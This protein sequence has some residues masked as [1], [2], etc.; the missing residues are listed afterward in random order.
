M[1][2]N[3]VASATFNER[4]Y[5]ALKMLFSSLATKS[6][7]SSSDPGH[8]VRCQRLVLWNSF[9]NNNTNSQSYGSSV[10]DRLPSTCSKLILRGGVELNVICRRCHRRTL[11]NPF[12]AIAADVPSSCVS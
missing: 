11:R 7:P 10:L 12:L 2:R 4:A 9:S 1:F 5:N 3:I 8:P 6:V